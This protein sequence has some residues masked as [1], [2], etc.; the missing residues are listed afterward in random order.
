MSFGF[1]GLC[2]LSLYIPNFLLTVFMYSIQLIY[3]SLLVRCA[4]VPQFRIRFKSWLSGGA[5]SA[6]T[7]EHIE[8]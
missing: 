7:V 5:D 4:A 8:K 3:F 6:L 2:G 1:N